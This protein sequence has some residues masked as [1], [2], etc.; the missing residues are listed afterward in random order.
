MVTPFQGFGLCASHH[1]GDA[2]VYRMVPPW[3]GEQALRQ[4]TRNPW[5]V[6]SMAD[7]KRRDG[8]FDLKGASHEQRIFVPI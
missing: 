2:L 4:L 1:Q 3:G 5:R 6:Q 7:E 8:S